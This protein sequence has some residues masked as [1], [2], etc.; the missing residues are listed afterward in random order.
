[1][2]DNNIKNN[3]SRLANLGVS[4]IDY[5]LLHNIQTVYYDGVYPNS[6]MPFYEDKYAPDHRHRPIAGSNFRLVSSLLFTGILHL[7]LMPS[8]QLKNS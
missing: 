7:H 1:M 5:Y 8:F 4:Y 6:E 2:K 3:E